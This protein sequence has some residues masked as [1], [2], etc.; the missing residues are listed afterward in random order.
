MAL[1]LF[2]TYLLPIRGIVR[3]TVNEGKIL[4]FRSVPKF[5]PQ[6]KKPASF[7]FSKLSNQLRLV[8]LHEIV[9]DDNSLIIL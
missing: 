4:I 8:L 1:L 9:F 3:V 7:T 2:C 6:R 5:R